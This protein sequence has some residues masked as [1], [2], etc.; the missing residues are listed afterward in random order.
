MG[1]SGE[2]GEFEISASDRR[3]VME[4]MNADHA[5]ALVLYARA[6]GTV[7]DVSAATMTD[8]DARL[9]CLRVDGADG[10][11]HIQIPLSRRIES[12]DQMRAVLVEMAANAR[13]LL[14]RE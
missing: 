6:F 2:P 10:P 4:H 13:T 8:I 5:D 9:M 14:A 11:Q 7:A 3:A 1:S 12:R